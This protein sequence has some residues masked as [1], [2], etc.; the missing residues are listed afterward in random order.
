[1]PDLVTAGEF[2]FDLIFHRL[3]HL[4]R[5]GEELKTN[6]FALALGGGAVTTALTAAKLG[7]KVEL[8]CTVGDT[9][10]DSFAL[11]ELQRG[12]VGTRHVKR[13]KGMIGAITVAVSLRRD[14]YF[15]TYPGA[16][17][18]LERHLLSA[19]V[20]RWLSRARHVH[21]ALSPR[22]WEPFAHVTTWL[23]RHGVTTSWDLGWN[24]ATARQP[25]FRRLRRL[26][27]V[28]FYNRDE[29]LLY[30]G[31]STPTEALAHL[32]QPGQVAVIK[33]GRAGAV[34][35]GRDG[36]PKRARAPKVRAIDTTG[37][38]DA[39]NG[40]FLHA[41]LDGAD[42]GDCLRTGNVCGALSTR[43]PG[44]SAGTP[45][46]AELARLLRRGQ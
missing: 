7:R 17:L 44:G 13:E 14:R 15:L 20:R 46:S 6:N 18:V 34:A 40:G 38:G 31:T 19:S 37:A 23:R 10:L 41:W 11:R 1:M 27:D 8:A 28:L 2:Y 26:L 45:T 25:G 42:L 3:A 22:R 9:A 4:P 21:F 35:V 32:T 12:K 5:L 24:P 36:R 30:S 16:N 43:V 39:F 33:L 29:A